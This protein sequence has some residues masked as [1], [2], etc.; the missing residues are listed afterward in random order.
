[1]LQQLTMA[2]ICDALQLRATHRAAAALNA[3][4]AS[5]ARI[6]QRPP[7]SGQRHVEPRLFRAPH[8][9]A[10]SARTGSAAL[11]AR[12]ETAVCVLPPAGLSSAALLASLCRGAMD[13]LLLLEGARLVWPD[14]KRRT[15]LGQGQKGARRLQSRHRFPSPCRAHATFFHVFNRARLWAALPP[16]P[17]SPQGEPV[18]RRQL[19]SRRCLARPA[20][21][22]ISVLLP[23]SF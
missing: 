10:A 11:V 7:W 22:L 18:R 19:L 4:L 17:K 16:G 12:W 20:A 3:P 6:S 23:A 9:R 1:M 2:A 13:N 15:S 14:E 5:V 21:H 8:R